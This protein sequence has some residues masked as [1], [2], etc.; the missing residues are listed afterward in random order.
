[1]ACFVRLDILKLLP[2]QSIDESSI[3]PNDDDLSDDEV[4]YPIEKFPYKLLYKIDHPYENDPRDRTQVMIDDAKY[5]I[6]RH[7]SNEG[8]YFNEDKNVYEFPIESMIPFIEEAD[9]I[10]ELRC[11]LRKAEYSIDDNDCVVVQPEEDSESEHSDY[12]DDYYPETAE[13]IK[14]SD[15]ANPDEDED[16]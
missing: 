13:A 4:I 16:W 14:T 7:L 2:K 10:N 9:D 11:L 6:N 1:M 8:L 3:L 5:F 15:N 12:Y